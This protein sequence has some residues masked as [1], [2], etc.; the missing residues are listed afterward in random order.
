MTCRRLLVISAVILACSSCSVAQLQ[1]VRAGII[2][3]RAGMVNCKITYDKDGMSS[4]S[5]ERPIVRIVQD[6]PV[7]AGCCHQPTR[8]DVMITR[9]HPRKECDWMGGKLVGKVCEGVDY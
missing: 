5:G 6:Q 9:E 1:Q 4:I 3:A 7:P 8:L 2:C